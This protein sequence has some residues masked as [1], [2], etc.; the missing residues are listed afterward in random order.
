M[1]ILPLY[2]QVACIS[3]ALGVGIEG[4]LLWT[5]AE[6]VKDA[7]GASVPLKFT[8]MILEVDSAATVFAAAGLV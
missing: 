6:A 8:S 5:S 4:M 2:V 7:L 3:L 1:Y